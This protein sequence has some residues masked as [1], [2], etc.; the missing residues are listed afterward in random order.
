MITTR[1]RRVWKSCSSSGGER[2]GF[3]ID[4]NIQTSPRRNLRGCFIAYSKVSFLALQR[5]VPYN[6]GCMEVHNYGLQKKKF[7]EMMRKARESRGMTI[8]EL[9]DPLTQCQV[10]KL[11]LATESLFL[12]T[13]L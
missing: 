5:I 12:Y 6:V 3:D 9:T 10:W 4:I 8:E 11:F 2:Q 13:G 7:A 1:F